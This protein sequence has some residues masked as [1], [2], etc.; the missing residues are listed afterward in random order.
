MNINVY[1][2]IKHVT[3]F[4]PS[5]TQAVGSRE[6]SGRT[7]CPLH[8]LLFFLFHY[9]IFVIHCPPSIINPFI[10]FCLRHLTMVNKFWQQKTT[11]AYP[12]YV[13][14]DQAYFYETV[15]VD[16]IARHRALN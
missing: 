12:G 14:D 8:P 15:V 13:I 6:Q 5:P 3:C 11:V 1:K 4:F 9:P 16:D 2:N 10:L 7:F